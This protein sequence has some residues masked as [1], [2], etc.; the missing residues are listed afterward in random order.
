[1]KILCYLLSIYIICLLGVPCQDTCDMSDNHKTEEPTSHDEKDCHQCSPF[2]HCNCCHVNTIV[3]LKII[4]NA[5]ETTPSVFVSIYKEIPV[6][7]IILHI[8]QPPKL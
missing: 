7:D 6:K 2:C 5:I 1:M 3:S 8:W 4:L